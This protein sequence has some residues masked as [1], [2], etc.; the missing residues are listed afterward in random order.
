MS[1]RVVQQQSAGDLCGG[2]KQNSN[3]LISLT[4]TPGTLKTGTNHKLA[5]PVL[6]EPLSSFFLCLG[7]NT[8]FAEF[9]YSPSVCI[10]YINSSTSLGSEAGKQKSEGKGA[11]LASRFLLASRGAA[12]APLARIAR[13]GV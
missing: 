4:T 8:A 13:E 7:E 12:S 5:P 6:I 10:L 2:R 9:K 3:P 11:L 1:S